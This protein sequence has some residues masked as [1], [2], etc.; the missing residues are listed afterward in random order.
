MSSTLS[1]F[2]L[3]VADIKPQVRL[4]SFKTGTLQLT[5]TQQHTPNPRASLLGLPVELRLQ[6]LENL[7]PDVDFVPFR[8]SYTQ[9]KALEAARP[10]AKPQCKECGH[11]PMPPPPSR[12]PWRALPRS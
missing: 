1:I 4:S 3:V 2:K 12:Y 7:L 10:V 5:S 11:W 8:F 6:I 9:A